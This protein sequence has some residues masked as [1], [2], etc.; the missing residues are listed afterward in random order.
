ML[1]DKLYLAPI[2]DNPQVSSHPDPR[3]SAL[4]F[5]L[6]ANLGRRN[7]LR[8]LGHVRFCLLPYKAN[9]DEPCPE[10]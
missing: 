7:R 10:T 5:F 9:A 8:H 2:G 6:A 1:D 3:D 4:T